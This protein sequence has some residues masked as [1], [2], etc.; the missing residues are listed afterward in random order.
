MPRELRYCRCRSLQQ[1]MAQDL[2]P[3]NSRPPM[4][5]AQLGLTRLLLLL[6]LRLLLSLQ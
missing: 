1:P 3:W 6:L 4:V 5:A 2:R